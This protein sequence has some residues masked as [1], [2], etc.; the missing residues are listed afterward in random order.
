MNILIVFATYSGATQTVAQLIGDILEKKGHGVT[1]IHPN[2]ATEDAIRSSDFVILCS[3]SWNVNGKEGQPHED[4][5]S[6]I[7]QKNITAF[8]GKHCAIVGLGDSSYPHFCGAVNVLETF[9]TEKHGIIETTSLRIDGFFYD[10]IRHTKTIER[11][12][13]DLAQHLVS[14]KK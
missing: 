6:L 5:F 12:T 3:P 14:M 8:G 1:M 7:E 11:W 13:N 2:L 4:F 10:E 9:I